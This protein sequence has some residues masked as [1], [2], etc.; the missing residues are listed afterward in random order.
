AGGGAAPHRQRRAGRDGL[1][2]AG[3]GPGRAGARAGLG[4]PGRHGGDRARGVRRD[5]RCG[6][7]P[8]GVH[9]G[10]GRAAGRGG[11]RAAGGVRRR[12]AGRLGLRD[13]RRAGPAGVVRAGAVGVVPRPQRGRPGGTPL[14][15]GGRAV[16]AVPASAGERWPTRGAALHAVRAGRHRTLGHP[17]R[18][19]SGLRHP[20][21][22][23]GPD[24]GRTPRRAGAAPRL[25]GAPRRGAPRSRDGVLRPGHLPL[26]PRRAGCPP[27]DLDPAR[28]LSPPTHGSPGLLLRS[29]RVQFACP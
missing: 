9:A 2:L 5:D 16:H 22:R 24:G 18:A 10:R 17:G 8:A 1:T 11:G 29:T 12:G 4:A 6:A 19:T 27:L 25:C 20:L 15:A 28:P 23:R 7:A 13:G 21:P 14:G 26:L 3:L